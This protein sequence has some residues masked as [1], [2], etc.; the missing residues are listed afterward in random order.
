MKKSLFILIAGAAL[1]AGCEQEKMPEPNAATC[2]PETF[3]A[4]LNDIREEVNR[5]AF[6]EECRAFQ[7]AKKMRQWEFKPSSE[8]N[9]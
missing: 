2:A 4:A 7:K 1:A 5:A 6:T 3:Q 8:D 9:Y